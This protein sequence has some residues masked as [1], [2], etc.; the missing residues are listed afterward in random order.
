LKKPY[1]EKNIKRFQKDKKYFKLLEKYRKKEIFIKNNLKF[2]QKQERLKKARESGWQNVLMGDTPRENK[3]VS[4][5][6]HSLF[7]RFHQM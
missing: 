3:E 6:E 5:H 7:L 1:S 4:L 2:S